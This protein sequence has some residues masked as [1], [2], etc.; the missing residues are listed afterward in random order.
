MRDHNGN[1][2]RP[3]SGVFEEAGEHRLRYVGFNGQSI[4]HT[5][6]SQRA[7][8]EHA[9]SAHFA[10]FVALSGAKSA[11]RRRNLSLLDTAGHLLLTTPTRCLGRWRRYSLASGLKKL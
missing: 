2:I 7:C 9:V 4:P 6:Q 3:E 5:P 11:F 8:L 10:P 1:L